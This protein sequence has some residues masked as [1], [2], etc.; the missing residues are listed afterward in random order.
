MDPQQGK[1]RMEHLIKKGTLNLKK[2][3]ADHFFSFQ[4]QHIPDSKR[5]A[6]SQRVGEENAENPGRTQGRE[7]NAQFVYVGVELFVG[8]VEEPVEHAAPHHAPDHAVAIAV[9][10]RV[11][12]DAQHGEHVGQ[13]LLLCAGVGSVRSQHQ[14]GGSD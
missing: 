4:K 1:S 7:L 14:K 9:A 10:S 2:F 13:P 12:H 3:R 11:D 5:G 8:I 6:Q